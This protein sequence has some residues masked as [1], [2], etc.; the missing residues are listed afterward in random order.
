MDASIF[1]SPWFK[2]RSLIYLTYKSSIK[3]KKAVQIGQPFL[4]AN[5]N[6]LEREVVKLINEQKPAGN[7]EVKFDASELSSG[8]YFYRLEVCSFVQTKKM[9]LLR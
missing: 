2:N 4:F 8:I 3:F 5:Y 6:T 9:I 7:Y 1:N